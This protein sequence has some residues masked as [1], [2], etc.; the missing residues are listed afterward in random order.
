MEW[1]LSQVLAA[2]HRDMQQRLETS[3]TSFGHPGTMGDATEGIWRELL[4]KYLPS[5]YAVAKAHVVDS[6]GSFS[7]Q[8][9]IAIFDRHYSPFIFN[10]EGQTI[11]PAESV[12]AVFEAKQT[13][14]AGIVAYAQ[15]KVASVRRLQRTTLA[16]PHAGGTYKPKPLIPILG[17]LL[18]LDSEWN[19]PLGDP[20]WKAV[21]TANDE[22][23]LD[24]GCIA[25]HGYFVQKAGSYQVYTGGKPAAAFLFHLIA[26]L[27][28]SGTV[29]M[30][31]VRAYARWLLDQ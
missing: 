10:Y 22:S 23:R 30:I 1:S 16:I 9:D 26:E 20:L 27:Q 13:C 3:R 11:V 5:R 8:I 31:D 6:Q 24:V 2:V 15:K 21:T 7:E 29:P 19:P 28:E 12:Y 14:D 18:A 4:E 17:G 25:A